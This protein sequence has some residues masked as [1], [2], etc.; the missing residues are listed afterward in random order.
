MAG[1]RERPA[2]RPIEEQWANLMM[3]PPDVRAMLDILAW[4]A[5]DPE[6]P[7]ALITH[8]AKRLYMRFRPYQPGHVPQD[9]A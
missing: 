3:P 5:M 6:H 8:E 2:A 9:R 4:V 1:K 7:D